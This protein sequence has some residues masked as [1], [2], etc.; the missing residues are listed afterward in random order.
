[1]FNI[2]DNIVYIDVTAFN[3]CYGVTNL[4]IQGNGAT[5]IGNNAFAGCSGL[6]SCTIGS[7]VTS[8]GTSAFKTCSSLINATIGS[9]SIG[10]EAFSGCSRL[11]SC[12]IGSGVTSIAN[13]AFGGCSGLTSIVIPSG[14]TSIGN[15]AFYYCS[16]LISVTV[17]ATTPPTLGTNVFQFTNDCPIYVPCDA[18]GAYKE[19][20]NW[21]SYASRIQA[22]P[23][24]CP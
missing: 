6:T 15:R 23:G 22:I 19:A 17:E 9:G 14:V 24:S 11:T 3:Y 16:G 20:T 10:E 13:Y 7:G 21:S 8:I 4:I 2:P 1:V 5:S 12:T 18:V